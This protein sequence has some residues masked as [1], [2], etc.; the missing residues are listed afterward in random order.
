MQTTE[1][2]GR[3]TGWASRRGFSPGLAPPLCV[4]HVPALSLAEPQ[5]PCQMRSNHCWGTFQLC[6][7]TSTPQPIQNEKPCSLTLAKNWMQAILLMPLWYCWETLARA[8]AHTHTHESSSC[9]HC[10][11]FLISF[12]CWF[13]L[14][15]LSCK[16]ISSHFSE[17]SRM[18]QTEYLLGFWLVDLGMCAQSLL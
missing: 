13:P 2:N 1:K 14:S 15:Q 7:H 3:S 9:N 16:A 18:H 8:H 5:V 10:T 4:C 17:I 6:T 11:D 12:F